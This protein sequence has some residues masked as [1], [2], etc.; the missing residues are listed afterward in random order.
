MTKPVADR[1]EA[2]VEYPFEQ[3][4]RFD[5]H[6][7]DTGISLSVERPGVDDVYKP[8]RMHFHYALFA[9][10]LRD[11]ANTARA[12]PGTDLEQR[13]ALRDAAR[14]LSLALASGEANDAADLTP[15]EEVGLLHILE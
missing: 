7:D 15:Q 6:F 13:K 3:T 12:R 14:A 10:I 4:A 1:A 9:E 5:A 11:L 8:V 2:S